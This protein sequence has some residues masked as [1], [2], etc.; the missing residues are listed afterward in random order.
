MPR[1]LQLS[2]QVFVFMTPVWP[3]GF[4][5]STPK[6]LLVGT[7]CDDLLFKVLVEDA[8]GDCRLL[9]DRT[10]RPLDHI[11][12]RELREVAKGF[13]NAAAD[14]I[15]RGGCWGSAGWWHAGPTQPSSQMQVDRD[16]QTPCPEQLPGQRGTPSSQDG[17]P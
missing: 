2:G 3:P 6:S 15:T 13:V 7:C 9:S 4:T 12:S 5:V 1:K 17:P 11:D 16:E 10:S 8:A 14:P